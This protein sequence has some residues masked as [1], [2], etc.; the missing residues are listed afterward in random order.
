MHFFKVPFLPFPRKRFFAGHHVN[1]MLLTYEYATYCHAKIWNLS[2]YIVATDILNAQMPMGKKSQ[3]QTGF[4][5]T[6]N[7]LIFL[8]ATL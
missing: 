1:E 7:R 5:L 6:G 3:K 2:R 4:Y 8:F